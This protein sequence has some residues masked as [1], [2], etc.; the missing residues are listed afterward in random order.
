[1]RAK[2]LVLA[3]LNVA[4]VTLGVA[5]TNARHA[6]AL[7][8]EIQAR[9]SAQAAVEAAPATVAVAWPRAVKAR[10]KN[11]LAVE[12]ATLESVRRHGL[13]TAG[14]CGL[15]TGGCWLG[16]GWLVIRRRRKDI[17]AAR[18][19]CLEP[20]ALRLV[21]HT[22][23][24]EGAYPPWKAEIA[25]ATLAG[26]SPGA[27]FVEGLALSSARLGLIMGAANGRFATGLLQR[28]LIRA[29]WRVRASAQESPYETLLALNTLLG[30]FLLPG[31][32]LTAFYA[33]LDAVSGEVSY[34]SAAHRSAYLLSKAGVSAIATGGKPLGIGPELF[35]ERLKQGTVRLQAG[36]SLW[37]CSPGILKLTNSA[38]EAFGPF[39]WES[40]LLAVRAEPAEAA[41]ESVRG[42]IEA[43]ASAG[44]R[45]TELVLGCLRLGPAE[46]S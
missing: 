12:H 42:E 31:D 40:C 15:V 26:A 32:L 9:L 33:R 5:Y 4:L 27:A 46:A 29:L 7:D 23:V 2:L 43:F 30:E 44:T 21:P 19:G 36:D 13:W 24:F 1:M 41:V 22:T 17:L 35:A 10:L 20:L 34:A 11:S 3:V 45:L 39:R 38:G 18:R 6:A 14:A 8:A 28:G 16:G 25:H 37:L